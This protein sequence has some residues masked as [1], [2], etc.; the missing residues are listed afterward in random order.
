LCTETLNSDFV[1]DS[2][3]DNATGITADNCVRLACP[4]NQFSR[5]GLWPCE[6]CPEGFTSPYLGT[7]EECFPL[8]QGEVLRKMYESTNGSMWTISPNNW[9]EGT[10][11]CQYTGITCNG[12]G[13]ITLISLPNAGLSGPFPNIIGFL[14]HLDYV[15]LSDNSLTGYLSADLQWPPIDHF[16]ISGNKLRGVIPPWLCLSGGMNENGEKGHFHCNLVAC[17][18]GTHSSIGRESLKDNIKCQPCKHD[19][20][21]YIGMKSCTAAAATDTPKKSFWGDLIKAPRPTVTINS[22]TAASSGPSASKVF[23]IIILVFASVGIVV[24]AALRISKKMK[25]KKEEEHEAL[26]TNISSMRSGSSWNLSN[27]EVL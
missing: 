1:T 24:F 13:H 26:N 11:E 20:A 2:L 14:E 21:I 23:G 10:D 15:D 27:R 5:E 16:D 22:T 9:Q 12:N 19:G 3:Y 8:D 17:P 6:D 4:T 25:A 18:A 7:E